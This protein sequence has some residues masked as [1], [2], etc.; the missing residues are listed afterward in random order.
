[1]GSAL[2]GSTAQFSNVLEFGHFTPENLTTARNGSVSLIY[3][4]LLMAMLLA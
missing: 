1:M 2:C 4:K 3:V